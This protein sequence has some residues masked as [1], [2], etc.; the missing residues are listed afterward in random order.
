MSTATRSLTSK[1]QHLMT[2]TDRYMEMNMKNLSRTFV[3]IVIAASVSA[4]VLASELEFKTDVVWDKATLALL[5]SGNAERGLNLSKKAKCTK[6]HGKTGVSDEDDTPS[7][8]GQ[9]RGYTYKEL[10]DYKTKARASKSMY[11]YTKKLSKQD[12]ADLAA[13][14]AIQTPE[15]MAN[16]DADAPELISKGDKKRLLLACAFC[17]GKDGLGK[18]VQSPLLAGQ[19]IE[20]LT[21]TLMAYKEGDRINDPAA[22]MQKIA[23]RLT[24]EEVET[25]AEYYAAAPAEDD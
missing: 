14:Y 9:I 10:V 8:A 13:W 24:D 4:N 5:D 18:K 20:Y 22:R 7:L 3:S 6:C 17:H 23:R 1:P 25:L 15:K 21:D 11:K 12:F 2:T 16:P 19:K